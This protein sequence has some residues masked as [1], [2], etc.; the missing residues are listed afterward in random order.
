MRDDRPALAATVHDRN[1]SILPGL[2]RTADDFSQ[3]FSGFGV[4]ATNETSNDVVTFLRHVLNAEV[5]RAPA[6]GRIGEHRR[7]ALGLAS[8]LSAPTVLYSDLDHVVRWIDADRAEVKCTVSDPSADLVVIGR[9]RSAMT[10]SPDR[11][12]A[13]ESLVNHVYR[14]ATGRPWDLMFATRLMSARAASTVL[15]RC[16]EDSIGSDVEW[17][18]VVEQAGLSISYLEAEALSYRTIDD[19][20]STAD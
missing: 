7:R 17:P 19:F 16:V 18:V 9:T 4:L 10:R 12:R 20:G 2:R 3:T 5:V 13:T 1:A 11:L 15:E 8:T 6:N 14:L